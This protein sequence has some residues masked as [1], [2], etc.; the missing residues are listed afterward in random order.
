MRLIDVLREDVLMS[1]EI[2]KC[3]R[4]GKI[5]YEV[6][7]ATNDLRRRSTHENIASA[8]RIAKRTLDHYEEDIMGKNPMKD[9]K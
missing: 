3:P 6:R 9:L 7:F 8:H 4:K 2:V 5:E 1:L